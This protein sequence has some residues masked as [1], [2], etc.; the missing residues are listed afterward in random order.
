M[1]LPR[2]LGDLRRSPFSEE[3][4]RTRRVKD[5]LR[6]NL[7]AQLHKSGDT[8]VFPGIVGYDDTVVPQ[9]TN[10]ILSRHN[11][12]LL[13]LRGQAKSRILRALTSLLDPHLPYI[14]GC[15]LHDNPYAPLCRRC[16]EELA[17]HGEQTAIAYLTP[18]QRYVEKLATPDVTIA[19]LI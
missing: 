9:I 11:F 4:L 8:P 12:I 5:E 14:A 19:D 10:A 17:K 16:H 2:T 6:E 3:R 1:S 15:E 7:T 18:E 13:G